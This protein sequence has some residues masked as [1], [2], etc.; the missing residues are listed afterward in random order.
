MPSVLDAHAPPALSRG[1]GVFP[2]II[3]MVLCGAAGLPRL[4][5]G[6]A[7]PAV[8]SFQLWDERATLP[9]RADIPAID[10]VRFSVI[11]P[12][13][14][15]KDGYRFLHGVGLCF[16][17]GRLYASFG[18]NTEGENTASEEARGR[19]SDDA[20]Q[21]WGDIF[22]IDAGDE[23]GLAVSHGVFL[24]HAGR[25]WAFM[26]AFHGAMKDVHAR[27]YVF[28]ESTLTWNRKGT[29]VGGGFWPLQEPLRMDDGNWIMAGIRVGAGNPA[30]V[31][32]S[33]GD[34]FLTWDLVVIPSEETNMWGESTVYVQGGTVVNIARWGGQPR[35]LVAVS[36]DH[37]RTW[38][39]SVASNLPMATSKPYAGTLSS[40]E[41]YLVGTTTADSGG[42]RVP[43]TI[44]LTRPGEMAFSRA[45]V[46]RHAVQEGGPGES[47][48]KVSLAYPY[49]IEHEG[50]LYVGYSN[51]GGRTGSARQQWN[52][53]SAELA[54]IPLG[55][56]R[57]PAGH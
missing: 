42:Q 12:Y 35:A 2:R 33:H 14:F 32:I 39:A 8:H 30:A 19:F 37:G 49:A 6:A 46:I 45:F 41:H 11:K 29:V 27:A 4:T 15:E 57:E 7:D 56:L 54:V 1:R 43:L 47:H 13:A 21:T 9:K 38:S 17:K 48:P 31:A 16:H 22:T 3:A 36:Q 40:G 53:N 51:S 44:L 5:A 34:D 50:S 18:H 52:N 26:G 23:P 24:S 55:R 28:D 25:L 20:G 10:A